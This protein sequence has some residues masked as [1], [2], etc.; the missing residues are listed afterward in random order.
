MRDLIK[1][2][3]LIILG[4]TFLFSLKT[5]AQNI[6]ESSLKTKMDSI[7]N[8]DRVGRSTNQTLLPNNSVQSIMTPSGWGGGNA[9][10][11]FGVIGG[12][13]PALYTEPNRGDLIAAVG[14]SGGDPAKY[15]NVS[16]S[17]NITRVTEMR[18]LSANI[19]ISRQIFRGSSISIGGLQLFASSKVSDAPDGT[20]YIAYSHA[21]QTVRSRTDG[22]SGLGYTIGYGV[23]R[24][25][26]KSP[27]DI[28]Y[29]KGKYGTGFFANVSYEI[30]RQV[31]LNAEWSGL[32]LGFSSGIRP[33][34]GS[35]LTFGFGIYNLTK[36]SG[37]RIQYIGSLGL[38]ILLG[39]RVENKRDRVDR[40]IRDKNTRE[41]RTPANFRGGENGLIM[42]Y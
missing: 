42:R 11:L 24:F 14:V 12:V 2:S 30:F 15:V 16:A 36:Y 38:P 3:S 13:F 39:K 6:F 23:G 22:Y 1:I 34:R 17:V 25:L 5:S 21:A 32:N 4:I 9:T 29:G 28:V 31:N 19:I 41:D 26:Y 7:I 35:A 27:Q 20:Y 8:D 37:D 40:T 10:Y 33:I 18:D